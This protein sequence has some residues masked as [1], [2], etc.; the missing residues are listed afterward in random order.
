MGIN[1]VHGKKI[2]E[3]YPCKLCCDPTALWASHKLPKI[4]L[5]PVWKLI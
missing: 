1:K 5:E 4:N 2:T 3:V